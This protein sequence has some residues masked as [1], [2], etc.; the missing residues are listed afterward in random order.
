LKIKRRYEKQL[1]SGLL[2]R[3]GWCNFTDVSEA[4]ATPIIRGITLMME[5]ARA[6]ETSVT[7]TRMHGA[8]FQNTEIFA[9]PP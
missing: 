7:Y 1:S 8:T 3:V 4:L 6:P 2:R 5:A 9:S